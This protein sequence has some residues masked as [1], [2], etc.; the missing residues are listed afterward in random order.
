MN[1]TKRTVAIG[2]I[3]A[4]TVAIVVFGLVSIASLSSRNASLTS[5]LSGQS[6]EI[7]SQG[8]QI[9]ALAIA[10][11]TVN[12]ARQ[13]ADT[14]GLGVCVSETTETLN[15]YDPPVTV[16]T[17]VTITSPVTVNGVTSC[18]IGDFTTVSPQSNG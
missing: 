4:V 1:I 18:A 13:S 17:G 11:N 6:R 9:S 10:Q 2:V 15:N 8:R 16:I 3:M 7:A 5:E 12:Q 14:A